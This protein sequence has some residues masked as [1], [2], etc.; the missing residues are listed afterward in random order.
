MDEVE[1]LVENIVFQSNDGAFCVF[2]AKSKE[3]G[4]VSVVY[5]GVAPF[6]G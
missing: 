6:V 2:R 4:S 5:R 1:F 3:N